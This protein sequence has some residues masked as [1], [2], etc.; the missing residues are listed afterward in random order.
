MLAV[1][2]IAAAAFFALRGPLPPPR[3]LSTQQL[4]SDSL[5][6]DLVVTDG[7][8][9]YFVESLNERAVLSQVSASGGEISHIPR[10]SRITF[11]SMF[12][13]SGRSF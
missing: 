2:A 10:P 11:C 5:P 7:P 13:R 6:K 12:L 4:T 1:A 3:V 8:R 9:V